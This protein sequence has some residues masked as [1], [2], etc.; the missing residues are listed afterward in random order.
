MYQFRA[1]SE[2]VWVQAIALSVLSINKVRKIWGWENGGQGKVYHCLLYT[3]TQKPNWQKR[4]SVD[5]GM[6]TEYPLEIVIV[7]IIICI[8]TAIKNIWC[9]EWYKRKRENL[10]PLI[11]KINGNQFLF[12]QCCNLFWKY[13]ELSDLMMS[14]FPL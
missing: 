9:L 2:I 14:V 6:R 7:S 5:N 8:Y 3:W 10:S 12:S 11:S 4:I 13:P 1:T